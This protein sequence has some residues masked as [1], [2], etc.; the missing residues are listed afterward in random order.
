MGL[1]WQI[2]EFAVFGPAVRELEQE[3]DEKK[4]QVPQ[5]T[6]SEFC[7]R[8]QIVEFAVFGSAIRD[9]FKSES[10]VDILITFKKGVNWS[11]L[12]LIQM[13]QELSFVFGRD[14]DLFTRKA[15]EQSSNWI[16]RRE[17]LDSAEVIYAAG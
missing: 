13:E 12:N 7:G 14:V 5:S 15:V 2:A 3:M 9:D 1:R 4:L 6:I 8:W 10:D 16:V 11:F 17:I